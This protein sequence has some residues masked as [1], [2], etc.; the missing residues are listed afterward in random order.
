MHSKKLCTFFT[1][2]ADFFTKWIFKSICRSHFV[3]FILFGLLATILCY[4]FYCC[5][6]EKCATR[7]RINAATTTSC[8]RAT[9]KTAGCRGALNTILHLLSQTHTHT[10]FRTY[11]HLLHIYCSTCICSMCAWRWSHRKWPNLFK[12]IKLWFIAARTACCC[13]ML[14]TICVCVCA[15]V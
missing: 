10:H 3:S 13:R 9:L 8:Y 4:G 2:L 5:H 14:S 1:P 6:F 15:T 12:Q 7:F 11:V